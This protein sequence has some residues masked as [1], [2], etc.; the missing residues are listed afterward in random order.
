MGRVIVIFLGFRIFLGLRIFP[1]FHL[2]MPLH[3]DRCSHA[4]W[5]G[6]ITK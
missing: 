3:A 6:V 1:S 4:Q 5:Q 2:P